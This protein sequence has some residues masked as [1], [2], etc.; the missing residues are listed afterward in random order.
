MQ[1]KINKKIVVGITA[2]L[3]VVLIKGQLKYF[4][5]LGYD[6]YLLAPKEDVVVEFCAQEGCTLLPVNIE[7]EISFIKDI[8]SLRTIIKHF[9]KVKPDVVNV[10]TPK[11]GLLG[12][13]AA[14]MTGVKNRIFT[15]RGF[16]Y[17]HETG[18]KK[19]IL[20]KLDRL[21]SKLAHTIIC[22]SPSVLEI[23]LQDKV[24]DKKKTVM[25]GAGSS[26]G[27][28]L[29]SFDPD[30]IDALKQ[31]ELKDRYA[32]EGKFVYGFVGRIVDRKGVAELFEAFDRLY[33]ENNNMFL[34]IVGKTNIEQVSDLSLLDK[35]ENH[36]AIA[37]TGYTNDVPLYIS[38]FDVFV[39]PAWWEGF[40]NTLIQAAAMGVPVISTT[41]TGCR[42]AVK[43]G[44]N[45]TLIE[46]KHTEELYSQMKRYFLDEKLRRTHGK[47]GVDWA[48]NFDSEF[49]W[50]TLRDIYESR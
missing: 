18:K 41:G 14:Y 39:L 15:C 3:S 42:D 34:F 11:M 8:A 29:K 25:I 17:E 33:S 1:K 24:L 6:T 4:S 5:D 50:K 47:N 7:R 38:L 2:P 44:Y 12:M 46:P 27:V 13:I 49:I 9:R 35:M 30:I 22:I 20:M 43:D 37:L 48:K 28:D 40:G 19:M 45:G 21:V 32:L 10:G 23:G 36:P 31:K 26:N 16:R